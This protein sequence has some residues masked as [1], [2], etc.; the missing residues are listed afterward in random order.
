MNQIRPPGSDNTAKTTYASEK[1]PGRTPVRYMQYINASGGQQR[2]EVAA[3][4]C[5]RHIMSHGFL[6][7]GQVY[8]RMNMSVK[9]SGV[10]QKMKNTH[11]DTWIPQIAYTRG[12]L[13]STEGV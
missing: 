7:T 12:R 3:F 10:V 9:A 13:P 8:G 5:D 2:A 11:Y 1:L 4:A 6:R